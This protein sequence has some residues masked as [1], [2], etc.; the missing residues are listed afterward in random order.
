LFLYCITF[1]KFEEISDDEKAEEEGDKGCTEN[2]ESN[3]KF[4]SSKKIK[5]KRVISDDDEEAELDFVNGDINPVVV[6]PKSTKKSKNSVGTPQVDDP[7]NLRY[8]EKHFSITITN[9]KG[10]VDRE[11]LYVLK[12]F[13]RE[14]P[15]FVWGAFSLEVGS[16]AHKLH[17]QG[18]AIMRWPTTKPSIALLAKHV[19]S[20][21]P[22]NGKGYR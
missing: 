4:K 16:K 11:L 15:A 10:D 12:N 1:L 6:V 21:F 5:R 13:M 19:K 2:Q 22:D 14:T 18:T 8:P 9:T 3:S 7:N 17:F 20:L